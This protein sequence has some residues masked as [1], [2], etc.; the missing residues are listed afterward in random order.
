MYYWLENCV[1]LS[2]ISLW[3]QPCTEKC[4]FNFVII[5]VDVRFRRWSIS[6]Q[7]ENESTK[8]RYCCPFHLNSSV[9]TINQG[10]SGVSYSFSRSFCWCHFMLLQTEHEVCSFSMSL[11]IE[12]QNTIPHALCFIHS[13]PGCPLWRIVIY[14]FW[15]T[16][17]SQFLGL[18]WQS[19]LFLW[20]HLGMGTT[21]GVQVKAL[22]VGLASPGVSFCIAVGMLHLRMYVLSTQVSMTKCVLQ[23]LPPSQLFHC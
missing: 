18:S 9:A 20:A 7:P 21:A 1:P 5:A 2:E 11:F 23:T 13:T 3:G 15:M 10:S 16:W 14:S 17:G 4:L 19:H 12:G 22:P 8:T 6:N